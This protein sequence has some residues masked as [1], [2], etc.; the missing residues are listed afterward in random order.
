MFFKFEHFCICGA[1]SPFAYALRAIVV[2]EFT[3]AEWS[4][5]ASPTSTLTVG[6]SSLESFGFF[7]DRSATAE[8]MGT[9][10]LCMVMAL[11]PASICP[12]KICHP[13]CL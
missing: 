2:N 1:C 11:Q 13:C 3:S 7:T 6:Q 10:G 12:C 8:L 9:S 4:A 5:R